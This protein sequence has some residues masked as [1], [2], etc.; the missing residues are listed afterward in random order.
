MKGKIVTLVVVVVLAVSLFVAT[1]LVQQS[2]ES[3][4]KAAENVTIPATGITLDMAVP[5][6]LSVGE[7]LSIDY[8]LLP[9][10]SDD[11]V[12]WS[13][14]SGSDVISIDND[15]V[16]R[17]L[18]P[19]KALV[20]ALTLV[21]EQFATLDVTVEDSRGD[22][23]S[24]GPHLYFS[25]DTNTCSTSQ[26]CVV[27]VKVDSESEKINGVDIIVF[28]DSSIL[29][30]KSAEKSSPFVFSSVD[31]GCVVNTEEEGR[32]M[33]TCYTNDAKDSLQVDGGL[34]DLVFIGKKGGS[35]GLKF[36]C[37]D[38]T[39]TDSNIVTLENREDII[40][41][42]ANGTSVVNVVK[43]LGLLDPTLGDDT[44]Y[45]NLSGRYINLALDK[46]Y[47]RV[48]SDD[49]LNN[50][51]S[52]L[53]TAY[54][55][56]FE[57]TGWKPYGGGKITIQSV[58]CGDNCY[59]WAWA[60]QT[61]SWARQWWQEDELKRIN[62]NDDWSFGIL[63]EISHDFDNYGVWDFDN[64]M[65][66]NFKMVYVLEKEKGRIQQNNKYYIGA[67]I[68]DFYKKANDYGYDAILKKYKDG[69]YDDLKN[70]IGNFLLYK[71]LD[72]RDDVG[73]WDTYKQVFRNLT[74]KG[75]LA[76]ENQKINAFLD[77]ISNVSHK[78]INTMFSEDEKAIL[79]LRFGS[80]F[81]E[82]EIF[83]L[84]DINQDGVVNS[85]DFSMVKAKL[86]V[87]DEK[88]DLNSDGVVNSIDLNLVKWSLF[89]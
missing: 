28:Y 69:K 13:V 35:T 15:G 70:T 89:N 53:D 36:D 45:K 62:D 64:E 26:P 5:V 77:E 82:F 39:S 49:Q 7:S 19:G 59:G 20:L 71:L 67:E 29:T 6:I 1:E 54:A 72:I 51:L 2:Q 76:S 86:G 10:G 48:I 88:T 32:L 74:S 25:S 56:Y 22:I 61:I 52:R 3:R 46:E 18:K 60:G 55:D 17:A 4:S 78:D 47:A 81:P 38:N 41:C 43:G 57:L 9:F 11:I 58:D 84:A 73:G 23:G 27:T 8:H 40:S 50:W 63:H 14:T 33:A 30:L 12:N 31:S 24:T 87:D 83:N 85:I 68:K 65:M 34:V 42:G 66:A 75:T 37:V 79:E 80:I 16:V 21:D 44:G